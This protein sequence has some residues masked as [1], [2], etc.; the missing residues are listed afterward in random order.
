MQMEKNQPL[1]LFL[2]KEMILMLARGSCFDEFLLPINVG[3]RAS[4]TMENL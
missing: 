1:T 4:N 3:A 2:R